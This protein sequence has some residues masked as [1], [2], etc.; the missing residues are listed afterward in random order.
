MVGQENGAGTKRIPSFE[1]KIAS[2]AEPGIRTR[3]VK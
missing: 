2:Q 3:K 1:A